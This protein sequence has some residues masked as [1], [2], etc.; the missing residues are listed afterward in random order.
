MANIETLYTLYNVEILFYADY[1]IF[2][3]L[4]MAKQPR[5][6][7]IDCKIRYYV[8]YNTLYSLYK[9]NHNNLF[10]HLIHHKSNF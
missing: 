6:I 2:H 10:W 8:T 3:W 5:I 4:K 7:I 9:N 1:V